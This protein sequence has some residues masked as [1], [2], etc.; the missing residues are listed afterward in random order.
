MEE[1]VPE[2]IAFFSELEDPRVVG[3][4]KHQ[5]IDIVTLVICG[6]LG[7]AEGW[8]E[9]E[10]YATLHEE[11]FRRFLDLPE[12]IP[13]HDTFRR[14]MGIIKPASI[15]TCYTAWAQSLTEPV[16][17]EIIAIDGKTA[18]RS[19]SAK[20][21]KSPLHL[22]SAFA[23][24]AGIVLG[25]EACDEKSNEITAIPKLLDTLDLKG[26]IVTTD[27][28]GSQ[29]T[30]AKQILDA[31]ADYCFALKGNHKV[32][33]AEAKAMFER[34]RK[35]RWRGVKYD[36]YQTEE[37]GHGRKEVRKYWTIRE[38]PI[39]EWWRQRLF[40]IEP[41]RGLKC[42]GVVESTRTV[43]GVTSKETRYYLTSLGNDAEQLARAV[44]GHWS[45]E[46]N[47]HWM[48]D[49]VFREDDDRNRTGH[50]Q[51]NLSL[52]RKVC[53]N[54]CK[55]YQDGSET[56]KGRRKKAGWD[57]NYMLKVLGGLP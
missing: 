42:I 32:L 13:S 20:T 41:W 39:T 52:V 26:K 21:G 18:R 57:V 45:V 4:S 9:V 46:N 36:W 38:E 12:G 28:L 40:K 19:G 56:I 7:N 30:I 29:K 22:V 6:V 51:N 47:L 55:L 43:N 8:R 14:V 49:V 3:R 17:R 35:R 53:L 1:R 11:L 25:Q 24:E 2:I 37:S 31:G 54:L 10:D 33:H 16:R 5:L 44:R 23:C 48:L 34:A 15:Q 50:A 27:A